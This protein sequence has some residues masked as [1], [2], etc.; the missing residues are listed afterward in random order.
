MVPKIIY[1]FNKNGFNLWFYK[2]LFDTS[3][4]IMY[5]QSVVSDTWNKSTC[6]SWTISNRIKYTVRPPKSI[7]R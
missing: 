5:Y 1:G 2:N 3:E 6:L 7:L 4:S